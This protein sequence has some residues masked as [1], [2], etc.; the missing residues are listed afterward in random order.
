MQ[1]PYYEDG[2][3][4]CPPEDCG[5]IW[6]YQNLLEIL[7]DPQHDRYNETVKLVSKGF[8]AEIFSVSITNKKLSNLV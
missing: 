6:G 7:N 8:H 3:C 5:G 4:S 2:E 1:L